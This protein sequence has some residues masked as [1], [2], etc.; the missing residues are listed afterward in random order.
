[1]HQ[2]LRKIH[3]RWLQRKE[4]EER[5]DVTE[6]EPGDRTAAD[7]PAE[8]ETPVAFVPRDLPTSTIDTDV[9]SSLLQ[10]ITPPST[11]RD[12]G[13]LLDTFGDARVSTVSSP[14]LSISTASDLTPTELDEEIWEGSRER[15]FTR[16]EMFYLEDGN[17]EIVCGRTIFR[18]HSPILSFSSQKL[19]DMLSP[20]A[21]L[22]VPMPEGCPRV[23]VTDSA[24]DFAILLKMIYTPG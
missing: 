2:E 10:V 11:L 23:A 17:V 24:Q 9:P 8:V 6:A 1:M 22:G 4:E 12:V 7:F 14:T 16:H 20:S 21:L 13:S 19:R 5:R 15:M 18:I 3:A